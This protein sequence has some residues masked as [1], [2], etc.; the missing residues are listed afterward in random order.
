MI[1][2]ENFINKEQIRD[3]ILN[4]IHILKKIPQE[5]KSVVKIHKMLKSANHIYLGNNIIFSL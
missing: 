1:K 3:A 2:L 4:E 5:V